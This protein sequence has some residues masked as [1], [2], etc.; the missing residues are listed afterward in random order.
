[1]PESE[2]PIKER[3]TAHGC[4][5]ANVGATAPVCPRAVYT[6]EDKEPVTAYTAIFTVPD[7]SPESEPKLPLANTL[8]CWPLNTFCAGSHRAPTALAEDGVVGKEPPGPAPAAPAHPGRGRGK[9][10]TAVPVPPTFDGVRPFTPKS[11]TLL[12]CSPYSTCERC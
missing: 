4:A 8:N 3:S 9:Y 7:G 1:M 5:D 2:S 10:L 6:G 11:S 12:M